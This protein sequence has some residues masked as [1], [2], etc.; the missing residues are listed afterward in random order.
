M[1]TKLNEVMK[2]RRS[3][4]VLERQETLTKGKVADIL[5]VA[6][7]A[8]SAFNMQSSRL[9]VLLD[10]AHEKFWDITGQ[11]LRKVTPAEA[12]ARTQKKLDGFRGGNGTILFF[13]NAEVVEKYKRDFSLY[14]DQFGRFS[15]H[16]NAILQYAV[17]LALAEEKLAASLQHY[18]PLIDS[19]VKEEWNIPESWSLIAQMPF[20]KGAE[21]PGPR[22]FKPFGEIVKFYE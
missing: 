17:W 1:R 21:T 10:A 9:I 2:D 13:E 7:H 22:E 11:E 15:Q 5:K 8:P 16:N 4:R 19:A 12:F 20:G 6:L 3:V 18:N 14:A